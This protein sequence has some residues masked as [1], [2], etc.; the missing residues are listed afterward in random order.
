ME[1]APMAI[2]MENYRSGLI[3]KLLMKNAYV[4]KGLQ[5]AGMKTIPDYTPGF[6]LAMVNTAT[7]VYDMMRHPDREKYEIDFYTKTSG[8]DLIS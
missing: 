7:G 2:M 4:Q 6:Y 5:L 3:W 8:R 1:H